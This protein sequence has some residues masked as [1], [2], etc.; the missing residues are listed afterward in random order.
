MQVNHLK[1]L[2]DI[3]YIAASRTGGGNGACDMVSDPF[4][5]ASFAN[6]EQRNAEKL[7]DPT[8][9]RIFGKTRMVEFSLDKDQF[10][11]MGDNSAKSLDARLWTSMSGGGQYVHRSYLIGRAAAVYWPHGLRIPLLNRAWCPNFGDVRFI[12]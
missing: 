7:S 6:A 3:Y 1:V 8:A 11:M 10:F 12:D 4:F 2:R 5:S 9:W